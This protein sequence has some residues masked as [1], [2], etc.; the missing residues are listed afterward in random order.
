MLSGHGFF[1]AKKDFVKG[2][3]VKGFWGM[4]GGNPASYPIK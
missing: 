2:S 4:A 3:G 1:Y